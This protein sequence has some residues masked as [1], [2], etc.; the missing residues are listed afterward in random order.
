[1]SDDKNPTGGVQKGDTHPTPSFRTIKTQTRPSIRSFGCVVKPTRIPDLLV[2]QNV[3]TDSIYQSSTGSQCDPVHTSEIECECDIP[4]ENRL[5]WL[6]EEEL[7]CMRLGK[8]LKDIDPSTF[9]KL[10]TQKHV[11]NSGE[12]IMR[13]VGTVVSKIKE[14]FGD[15]AKYTCFNNVAKATSDVCGIGRSTVIRRTPLRVNPPKKRLR[16]M[17]KKEKNRHYVQEIDILK[18]SKII[19][20]IHEIWKKGKD[21]VTDE[22]WKWAQT[23][24]QFDKCHTIFL[25]VLHGLGFVYKKKGENTIVFERKDIIQKCAVYLKNKK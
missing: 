11:K 15:D 13:N 1:M 24:I 22:L 16:D 8:A 23:E 3:A 21:V 18:R 25:H 6:T 19:K 2:H 20:E 17:S 7:V 14:S 9:P 10:T 4:P 5:M 12:E